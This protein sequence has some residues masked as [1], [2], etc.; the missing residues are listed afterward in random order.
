[1]D[2]FVRLALLIL[3]LV[4][5]LA[6]ATNAGAAPP[7]RVL[8]VVMDQLRPDMV[9]PFD[10]D[11]MRALMGA[12]VSYPNAYV[13]HMG[14]ET[15]ISHGVMTTG[16]LPKRLGW[17]DEV[18][19]DVRNVLGA[20][21]GAFHVTSSFSAAEFF[22]LQTDAGYP[23]LGDYLRAKFPGTKF[24]TVGMKT[25]ATF[26]S[27]GPRADVIVTMSGRRTTTT[28]PCFG[29]LGGRFRG[30]A[31][32][33]VP[34]YLAG[35]GEC[36][37]FYVNSDTG[38]TYTT[39]TTSPAWMYPLDGD[40]FVP[41]FNQGHLGGDT[42]VADAAMEMMEREPW[43]G[44]LVS[45][46]GIDKAG[47]MWG[48][49]ND[50]VVYP[51]GSPQEMAHERFIAKNADNQLGRMIDK[52]RA[53][54]QLDETLIFVTADHAGQPSLNFHGQDGFDRGNFNWY[55]GRD[56][57]ETYLMPQP[58]L[59]PLIATGN[60]GFNYQD[61]A[62]RTWLTDQS[63]ARKQE[64]ATVMTTLPNV[65]ATYYR[66]GDR[67]VLH[68]STTGTPMT[69]SE[70][71]WWQA[72]GQELVDTMAADW[73]AD[74]VGLLSDNT[75]YGVAGD[76]GGHQAPIQRIPNVIWSADVRPRTRPAAPFRNADILP[77]TLEI[78]GIRRTAPVDGR[79]R[80]VYP[81]RARTAVEAHAGAHR[82]LRVTA[83]VLGRP[84]AG[85][86]VT[87][88]GAGVARSGRTNA[89][90]V[91]TLEFMARR[92]GTLRVN[93]RERGISLGCRA[94]RRIRGVA[95]GTLGGLTGRS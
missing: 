12:G 22:A 41:G 14:A 16:L 87:L 2:R 49:I 56:S 42:W 38:N 93:V 21:P 54:G 89:S 15:V 63:L 13:G 18:H 11:Q 73:S 5:S 91:A 33:N 1:V 94:T 72:H 40:R 3:A 28:A 70:R 50:T 55:Y 81:C 86:L 95:A 24:I 9:E 31:G 35:S 4:V 60:I 64:A 29:T 67:Y 61:G 48:G 69:A 85:A 84:V 45:L 74:V 19:R 20:G 53:L 75:S 66:D 43:S 78:L 44:M 59:Q 46:G 39:G 25:T 90:G 65:I 26:T 23:N 36:G 83:H 82:E 52:L 8:I 27:G 57:D 47:H 6:G 37:R 92:T 30:P 58:Q 34:T 76:H 77:T 71:R 68:S 88:R 80:P 17:S 10:M 7:K 51:P 79:V 62:I 32:V